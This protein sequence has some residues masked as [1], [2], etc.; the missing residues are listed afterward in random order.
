MIPTCARPATSVFCP[1]PCP[2]TSADGL[3]TRRYSAGRR[4]RLPSSK[5]TSSSF[6]AFLRRSSTGQRVVPPV[7]TRAPSGLR[8]GLRR[9]LVVAQPPRLVDQHDRDAVADRIGEPRLLADQLLGFAVVAQRRLA[10]RTDEDLEQSRVDFRCPFHAVL[11][12]PI[13]RVN[14]ARRGRRAPGS[15]P[16]SR[17]SRSAAGRARRGSAPRAAP[18]S[19]SA[20]TG[21]SSRSR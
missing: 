6:S 14:A 15:A 2:C 20:R 9:L 10:Q 8:R 19:R 21:R 17:P 16:P 1:G 11:P 5:V 4:K 3:S 7:F 18:A 13:A 12:G